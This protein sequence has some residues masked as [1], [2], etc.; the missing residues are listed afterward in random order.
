MIKNGKSN[1][2]MTKI[3]S[4]KNKNRICLG[5]N[6]PLATPMC[7]FIDVSSLCN[8][9]CEFCAAHFSK[10][11]KAQKY[12]LMSYDLFVKI[13][14]DLK[15]FPDKIKII[16][17]AHLGEPLLNPQ[18]PDMIRYAKSA[19]VAEKIEIITNGSLLSKELNRKII[20]SG[21][22]MIRISIE[23]L[24][25]E[26]YKKIANANIDYGAFVNNIQDLYLNKKQAQVYIKIADVSVP[27]S[28]LQN[29]FFEMFEKYCDVINIEHICPSWVGFESKHFE[30]A[31]LTMYG[32]AIRRTEVCSQPFYYMLVSSNGIVTP[33]CADWKKQLAYGDVKRKSLKEI[34]DGKELRNFWEQMLEKRKK[35][36]PV[37]RECQN[38]DYNP[39]DDID[40]YVDNIKDRI[41]Y[42][43]EG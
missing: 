42:R 11:G 12:E 13:I 16:R 31:K 22:D 29:R 41:Y 25:S 32:E 21:I 28:E 8:F 1:M 19:G 23:A 6:I 27:S 35:G 4:F 24:D 38:N 10:E 2:K 15:D 26:G 9:Q 3:G 7:L 18:L 20:E 36:I 39:V 5:E 34:W 30:Q 14:D 40:D 17:L 43:E 33:C 37:C